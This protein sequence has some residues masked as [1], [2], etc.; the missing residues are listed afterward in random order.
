MILA[1]F[2][3][4]PWVALLAY[5]T[6]QSWFWCH[7]CLNIIIASGYFSISWGIDLFPFFGPQAEQ[8]EDGSVGDYFANQSFWPP[9]FA[10]CPAV[11]I[12]TG[13]IT[14]WVHVSDV[15]MSWRVP[16]WLC[17]QWEGNLLFDCTREQHLL[18]FF[19]LFLTRQLSFFL[20]F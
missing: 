18:F 1:E 20:F 11:S 9:V 16:I 19:F 6:E 14:G 2:N 8:K 7:G 13:L 3:V 10:Y 12:G 17:R 5:P 4:K 15:F